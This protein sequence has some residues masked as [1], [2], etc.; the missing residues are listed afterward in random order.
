MWKYFT[1]EA[2]EAIYYAEQA[3]IEERTKCVEAHHLLIGVL[4]VN[5]DEVNRV[6][7]HFSSNVQF[8]REQVR[9]TVGPPLAAETTGE[10]SLS[11]QGKKVLDN[12]YDEA[13]LAQ[14]GKMIKPI[15][16]FLALIQGD[17]LAGKVLRE[18]GFD[19]IEA[20]DCLQLKQ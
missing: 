8:I 1:E 19:I 10:I 9:R 12:M 6:L 20:R 3:T 7:V 4:A 13:R 17:H 5:D 16:I 11:S 15:F 18:L 14:S 2:R